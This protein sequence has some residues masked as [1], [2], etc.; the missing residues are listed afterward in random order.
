[1][2]RADHPTIYEKNQDIKQSGAGHVHVNCN[3]FFIS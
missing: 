2:K 1:M 3:H